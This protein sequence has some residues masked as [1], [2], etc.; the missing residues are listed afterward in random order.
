MRACSDPEATAKYVLAA[1][2]ISDVPALRLDEIASAQHIK[3][4]RNELPDDKTFSGAL[5]FKGTQKAIL[6]NTAI[7]HPGRINFTFAHELGHHF[8]EHQ[9]DIQE[10]GQVGFWCCLKEME[11]PHRPQ[12]VAANQFAAALLMPAEQMRILMSGAP[13][14]YTL[15]SS[16]A[17]YFCVSKYAC[18][19]RILALTTEP[20]IIIR[21][22]GFSITG[23][24]A[25]V[26]ARRRLRSLTQ[27][28]FDTAAYYA[29]L[30]QKNQLE[31]TECDPRRWVVQYD[32][33]MRLFTCTRG[34]WI[35]NV[36]MTI[37]KW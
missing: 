1:M 36:A 24:S 22:K 4:G 13:L 8:L 31:F 2:S 37:L 6:L 11:E 7:A 32:Q 10:S 9:P 27:I 16:L 26:T 21:T 5:L 35:H 28:P 3:V 23:Q 20:C 19:N 14:D 15:V 29:I 25:S 34:D 17:R 30:H 33:N 18:A 12:E